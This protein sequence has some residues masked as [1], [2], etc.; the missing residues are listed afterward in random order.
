MTAAGCHVAFE[1]GEASQVGEARRAA[2][3]QAEALGLGSVASGRVALLATELGNNL[4]RHATRGRLLLGVVEGRAGR[5]ALELLS[6][7]HGPGIANLAAAMEDGFSTGGTPGNGLGAVRRMADEFDVY[8]Q[9]PA[10][11]VIMARVDADGGAAGAGGASGAVKAGLSCGGVALAAP[12]EQ[13]CGDAWRIVRDG[14]RWSVL[15][16]D[17]LGHGPVAREAALAALDAFDSDAFQG[18]SVVLGRVHQ[19]LRATRGA[20]VAMAQR[21]SATGRIVYS[22]AGN[23]SG[24][25]LS[26]VSDRTLLS[27]HGTAGVQIRAL[28][29]IDYEWPEH[30][31]L[32]MHSDGL[33]T[34]WSLGESQAL[35]QRHPSVVAAWLVRD[36]TRGPDDVTVVVVKGGVER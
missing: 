24:R 6:L 4:V 35:L 30:G 36:H 21:V 16:A 17:G 27:Q 32:V 19:E 20:A 34:R 26:G 22:G 1:V 12:G 11:T 8:S 33:K 25:L 28:R 2:V 13:V 31:L 5:P 15:V 18:P 14:D 3:Q 7:D 9:P 23:I 29:D 10:G